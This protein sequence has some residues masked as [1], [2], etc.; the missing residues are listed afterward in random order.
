M[1]TRFSFVFHLRTG[2]NEIG[3]TSNEIRCMT[4]VVNV[5]AYRNRSC[6]VFFDRYDNGKNE[7]NCK[8][9]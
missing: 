9:Q 4:F 7:T 5:S 8:V 3:T 2:L 6:C 1:R